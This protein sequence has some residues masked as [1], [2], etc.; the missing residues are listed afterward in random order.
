[1]RLLKRALRQYLRRRGWVVY[2]TR[3]PLVQSLAAVP[4]FATQFTTDCPATY[5]LP[6]SYT[7]REAESYFNDTTSTDE[8][9]R[10]VY[11]LARRFADRDGLKT[12]CDIGCGS[13]YKLVRD[14]DGLKTI[15]VEVPETVAWLERRYP[16]HTW[17]VEDLRRPSSVRADMVIASDII[18]HLADPDLLLSYI[19]SMEP[20]LIVLS[21]PDRH[22]LLDGCHNGPP[23][24]PRHIREWGF[25]EFHRYIA[26]R[27]E[28]LERF[29][30]NPYQVTQM[31]VAR[32]RS[33]GPGQAA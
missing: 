28:I 9:Q 16:R 8:F 18:E 10:E 11:Q 22:L 25:L 24:N 2:R 17:L 26:D 19:A 6:A 14:F 1:V 12:V 29:Y 33:P 20:R 15:G 4:G 13:A 21:T 27:F 32:P 31:V 7:P 5:Y 30:S 3:E 23:L